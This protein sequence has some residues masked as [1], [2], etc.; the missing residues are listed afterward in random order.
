MKIC[1]VFLAL[2]VAGCAARK[3][4]PDPSSENVWACRPTD[5]TNPPCHQVVPPEKIPEGY[6]CKSTTVG[7]GSAVVVCEPPQ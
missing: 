3:K 1:L 5:G 7:D 2:A 6:K 4:H